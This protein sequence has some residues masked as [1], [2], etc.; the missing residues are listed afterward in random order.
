ML[1]A[2]MAGVADA[3]ILKGNQLIAVAKTLVDSSMSISV[4]AE[5]V[6]AGKGAGLLGRYFHTSMVTLEIVDTIF[7][8]DY[9]AMNVGAV[10]SIGGEALVEEEVVIATDNTITASQTPVK[11]LDQG[12]IGWYAPVGSDNFMPMTFT[13][14]T[15]IVNGVKAGEMYCIKYNAYNTSL[16]EVIISADIIPDEVTIILKGDLFLAEKPGDM[17][18]ASLIGQVETVV[19]RFQL[20]GNMDLSMTMT[21]ASQTALSGMALKTTDAESC[22]RGGYYAKIKQIQTNA[23]WT[24]ELITLA[25][26]GGDVE[27]SNI[28][29]PTDKIP[30]IVYGVFKNSRSI[31]IKPELLTFTSDGGAGMYTVDGQGHVTKGTATDADTATI[32]VSIKDA[33]GRLT[34]IKDSVEVS[35][36]A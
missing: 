14:D 22:N 11:F 2:F 31:P 13:G 25:I 19:P 10:K 6:R 21:G 32:T 27:F 33:T 34:Q 5:E 12:I 28:S 16:E 29:Q 17:A 26:D 30:L 23:S 8:S 36:M 15:A 1:N 20:N 7:R 35:T 9:I 3:Y 24:D 4:T 18:G